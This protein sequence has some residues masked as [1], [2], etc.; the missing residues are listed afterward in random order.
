MNKAIIASDFF[1]EVDGLKKRSE[2]KNGSKKKDERQHT[3]L[4]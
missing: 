3:I 2:A 1:K 4:V